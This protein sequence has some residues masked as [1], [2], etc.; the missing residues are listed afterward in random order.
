M[1]PLAEC[2]RS[3]VRH[4]QQPER[5]RTV[6][7]SITPY[8]TTHHRHLLHSVKKIGLERT[9]TG[10]L[11]S[12]KTLLST[13]NVASSVCA[14]CTESSPATALARAPS[15]PV[16]GA[17]AGGHIKVFPECPWCPLLY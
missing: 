13:W 11:L 12:V 6:E 8:A 16:A 14:F 17:P 2:R 4:R 9:T 15:L 7:A 3:C 5:P 1:L 10:E